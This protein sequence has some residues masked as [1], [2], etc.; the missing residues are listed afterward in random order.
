[1]MSGLFYI[2]KKDTA[3][4]RDGLIKKMYVSISVVLRFV[5]QGSL[6][7][8]VFDCTPLVLRTEINKDLSYKCS[9]VHNLHKCK[10]SQV[11]VK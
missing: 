9:L 1:M 10:L 7:S 4:N 2:T 11:R 3:V 6:E 5:C 8:Y